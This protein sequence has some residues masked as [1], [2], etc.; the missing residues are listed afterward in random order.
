MNNRDCSFLTLSQ[1][2]K[3]TKNISFDIFGAKNRFL[4]FA[5][6]IQM[7]YFWR[8]SNTVFYLPLSEQAFLHRFVFKSQYSAL[9]QSSLIKHSMRWFKVKENFKIIIHIL[10]H[11]IV[12]STIYLQWRFRLNLGPRVNLCQK[13][14]RNFRWQKESR[15]RL[16]AELFLCPHCWIRWHV[17]GLEKLEGGLLLSVLLSLFFVLS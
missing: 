12:R 3:I 14:R 16:H 11:E 7:R 1:F 5:V 6:K 17:A 15:L 8:F 2:L 9:G 10:L 13:K 4:I